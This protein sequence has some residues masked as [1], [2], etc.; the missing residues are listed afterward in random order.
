MGTESQ[1]AQ[2][3]ADAVRISLCLG[4]FGILVACC[5][6]RWEERRSSGCVIN[7]V[8][9]CNFCATDN[10]N[11]HEPTHAC[12]V[13]VSG[14]VHLDYSLFSWL[15][16]RHVQLHIS[17]IKNPGLVVSMLVLYCFSFIWKHVSVHCMG[18]P[19]RGGGWIILWKKKL[20]C[21]TAHKE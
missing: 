15:W 3:V 6:L 13:Q 19:T 4:A 8:A 2:T 1:K 5:A 12:W 7:V 9:R 21:V 10:C 14:T 20:L 18:I 11:S 17:E 16:R